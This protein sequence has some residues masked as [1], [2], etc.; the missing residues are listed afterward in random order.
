MVTSRDDAFLSPHFQ[1]AEFACH[2]GTPTPPEATFHLVR[3]CQM[4]LEGIR[5]DW[6][7]SIVVVSGYRSPQHN[8]AVGGAK[9][10][11][12]VIGTAADIRPIDMSR[13]EEFIACCER[14]V[15]RYPAIGGIGIYKGWVHIDVRDREN[16]HVARWTGK[17][18]GSEPS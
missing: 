17:G 11:Q 2:D 10:S 6:G 16:G 1:L 15:D 13:M 9:R 7:G 8:K 5:A 18:I 14:A 12:H 4:A 3:L